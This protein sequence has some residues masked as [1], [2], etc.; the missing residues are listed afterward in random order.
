M[1]FL[2]PYQYCL[3]NCVFV[4][5]ILLENVLSP[6]DLHYFRISDLIFFL[7]YI[8][9]KICLYPRIIPSEI[10]VRKS[11]MR[12]CQLPIPMCMFI[13]LVFIYEPIDLSV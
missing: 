1:Y 10:Q 5:Y 9:E 12:I 13:F 3:I 11:Q 6:V 7:T 8:L 2:C 4:Y